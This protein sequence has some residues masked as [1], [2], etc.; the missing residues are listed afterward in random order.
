MHAL[1]AA[2]RL[3]R[4]LATLGAL[5]TASA[6]ASA[7]F[8]EGTVGGVGPWPLFPPYEEG[9]PVSEAQPNWETG[10][11]E[12]P[13]VFSAWKGVFHDGSGPLGTYDPKMD[14]HFLIDPCGEQDG[15]RILL[16]FDLFETEYLTDRFTVYDGRTKDAEVLAELSGDSPPAKFAGGLASGACCARRRPPPRRASG[17]ATRASAPRVGRGGAGGAR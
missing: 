17:A 15:C 12:E 13:V 4:L 10:T 14:S 7:L 3:G 1:P 2:P 5:G 9:H 6:P 16:W 11:E 8:P